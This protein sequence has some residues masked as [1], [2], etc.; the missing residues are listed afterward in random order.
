MATCLSCGHNTLNGSAF[1][2]SCGASQNAGLSTSAGLASNAAGALA[3][4]AGI[5][6]GTIF[7]LLAPYK[8]DHF[9][10][11][12]AI[13]SILLNIAWIVFWIVWGFM[14]VFFGPRAGGLFSVAVFPV[15]L[16]FMLGSFA[17]WLYLMH[18]AYKGY[19]FYLPILGNIAAKQA[20]LP[21]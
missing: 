5:I 19:L 4:V 10:R 8:N 18:S 15:Y 14:S 20:G 7:L 11:F 17:L 21:A 3:Y 2:S 13:Q 12:H 9:V 16:I 6:T 1:C